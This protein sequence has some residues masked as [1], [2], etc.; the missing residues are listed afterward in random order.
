MVAVTVNT[1]ENGTTVAVRHVVRRCGQ[2]RSEETTSK[3]KM[4]KIGKFVEE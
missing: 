3:P 1:M 2:G 4:A